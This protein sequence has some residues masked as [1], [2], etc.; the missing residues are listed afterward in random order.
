M[1][2]LSVRFGDNFVVTDEVLK[3]EGFRIR[4]NVGNRLD[5]AEFV[6]RAKPG[7]V[8]LLNLG[9][10]DDVYIYEENA[11][12]VLYQHSNLKGSGWETADSPRYALGQ[13][14]TPTSNHMVKK[15]RI[16]VSRNGSKPGQYVTF[17]IE[18]TTG[19]LPNGEIMRSKTVAFDDLPLDE[20]WLGT[21]WYEVEFDRSMPVYSGTVYAITVTPDTIA[22]IM[23][24]YVS[25][26]K[27]QAYAGGRGA[28][29]DSLGVWTGQAY[30]LMFEVYDERELRHFA[31]EVISVDQHKLGVGAD[32]KRL[33]V[34]RAQDWTILPQ[35]VIVNESY[36]NK[37]DAEIVQDL[38]SKYLPEVDTT[39]YVEGGYTFPNMVFNYITLG[40]ALDL[41]SKQTG[42]FWY[43]DFWKNLHYRGKESEPAP[44]D[45]SDTPDNVNTFNCRI[46]NNK[47]DG[48][49]HLIN[50]VYIIGP[51]VP[52]SDEETYYDVQDRGAA[53]YR[54][55]IVLLDAIRYPASGESEILLYVNKG[56]DAS[57]DWQS[58][59][60]SR[61]VAAL[62]G[63]RPDKVYYKDNAILNDMTT[64]YDDDPTTSYTIPA[65]VAAEDAILVGFNDYFWAVQFMMV[66][67]SENKNA[68]VMTIEYS[69]GALGW[70]AAT[71]WEDGTSV[72]GKS[73]GKYHGTNRFGVSFTPDV[74]W[75]K[76]NWGGN[77]L[78]WLK[79]TFS[80]DLSA[81]IKIA[82]INVYSGLAPD[83]GPAPACY[84]PE[85]ARIYFGFS[86]KD[87]DFAVK[88]TGRIRQPLRTVVE[89]QESHNRYG[90]WYEG[91]IRDNTLASLSEAKA[92]GKAE[93]RETALAR[94][95]IRV[96]CWQDGLRAGMYIGLKDDFYNINGHFLIQSLEMAYDQDGVMEYELDLGAYDPDLLDTIGKIQELAAGKF[97]EPPGPIL[98]DV[99]ILRARVGL[100][101]S[102]TIRDA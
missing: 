87:I 8:D 28:T 45:F 71:I 25:W 6:L 102:V 14:F 76:D 86:P 92:V 32:A 68:S 55:N 72:S 85:I 48:G 7:V 52:G 2:N 1:P 35:T 4:Q 59:P 50:R 54:D 19:A 46:D 91:V 83:K 93:L 81:N 15:I 88:V 70:L 69:D 18:R 40:Q 12:D 9:V 62:K 49:P 94:W 78:Y 99:S 17:A 58:V 60:V 89:D 31:G 53:A 65:F 63:S 5:V 90:R 36:T 77:E 37:T 95:T 64:A 33:L 43:I 101:G 73:L 82:E 57:P 26:Y 30:D 13:P 97:A 11:E 44:F 24:S 100:T 34:C 16:K 38:F 29:K 20:L 56:T 84:A 3:R 74:D 42:K 96:T 23:L 66:M 47:K 79:I 98:K 27:S 61:D 22:P 80:A 67:G 75:H 39:E 41:M 10:K 21:Y 51:T